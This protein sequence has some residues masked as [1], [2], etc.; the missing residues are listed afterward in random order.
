MIRLTFLDQHAPNFR[1]MT[2][3]VVASLSMATLTT[4]SVSTPSVAEQVKFQMPA[5]VSPAVDIDG[6]VR[7]KVRFGI[8]TDQASAPQSGNVGGGT[9]GNVQ[10]RPPGNAAPRNTA[11]GGTRGELQLSN[12][13]EL[14]PTL[15]VNDDL[16]D[17][18][19]VE[20]VDSSVSSLAVEPNSVEL[21]AVQDEFATLLPYGLRIGRTVSAHPTF[22]VRVPAVP[23]QNRDNGTADGRVARSAFFSIQDEAGNSHYHATIPLPDE[24][25]IISV[26][27]PAEAPELQ[28]EVNYLWSFVPLQ[29]GEILRPDSYTLAA[30]VKRVALGEISV[31]STD[32]TS[33]DLTS[34]NLARVSSSVAITQAAAYASAGIWYDTLEVLSDALQ[35]DPN[36]PVVAQEWADLLEQVG[37]DIFVDEAVLPVF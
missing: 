24:G 7:G 23:V 28:P 21:D 22:F 14:A 11:S 5:D 35:A 30:W 26:A 25:G 12:I 9:R 27:L 20:S 31:A 34:A 33:A 18:F 1:Q 15:V 16:H 37:L 6:N 10:F 8:P 29:S 4:L 32:S 19:S 2:S 17:E 3:C 13:T 36:S